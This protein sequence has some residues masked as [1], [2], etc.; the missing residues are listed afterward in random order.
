ML[1][2]CIYF[3]CS[4]FRMNCLSSRNATTY[5]SWH[6]KQKLHV[7]WRT[8]Q[9]RP[10]KFCVCRFQG[11]CC[12]SAWNVLVFAIFNHQTPCKE[13]NAKFDWDFHQWRINLWKTSLFFLHWNSRNW[14]NAR[15]LKV[16]ENRQLRVTCACK[17]PQNYLDVGD[18]NFQAAHWMKK[19]FEV[20]VLNTGASI[21]LCPT[22]PFS[23][24]VCTR[25]TNT[26]AVWSN[27][28][29]TFLS[30]AKFLTIEL[31]KKG[32]T[33][34][35]HILYFVWFSQPIVLFLIVWNRWLS[36]L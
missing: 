10:A 21:E 11:L 8:S 32:L 3:T 19:K 24:L 14:S 34:D 13:N 5:A 23:F 6:A 9:W 35:G 4:A 16:S 20:R 12:V 2:L 33:N 25:L 15:I 29:T 27:F 26:F 30:E 28:C 17:K 7:G 18:G 36:P 1:L 22:L 31:F